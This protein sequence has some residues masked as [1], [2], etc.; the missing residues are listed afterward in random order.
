[1]KGL[2]GVAY[3]LIRIPVGSR[4]VEDAMRCCQVNRTRRIFLIRSALNVVDLCMDLR[5]IALPR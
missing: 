4:H 5:R 2:T 1:M 3:N